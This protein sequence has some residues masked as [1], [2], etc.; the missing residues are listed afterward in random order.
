MF[1]QGQRLNKIIAVTFLLLFCFV[2]IAKATHTHTSQIISK[3]KKAIANQS[4]L[5]P[6]CSICDFHL[7]QEILIQISF[8][9]E[10][11]VSQKCFKL[12]NF[13]SS[14]HTISA[15][16]LLLRGPPMFS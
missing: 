7:A 1:A 14:L 16:S 5:T 8:A 15:N 12:F 11:N 13:Q 6:A 2:H 3:G 9:I 10:P 4:H